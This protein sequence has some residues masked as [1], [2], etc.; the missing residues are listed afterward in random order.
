M[1][2][3]IIEWSYLN[4]IEVHCVSEKDAVCEQYEYRVHQPRNF[5]HC[6]NINF[7]TI[8]L[9]ASKLYEML[10]PIEAQQSFLFLFLF[11]VHKKFTIE[12][13]FRVTMVTFDHNYLG[14]QIETQNF[15]HVTT[16]RIIFLH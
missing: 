2:Q 11:C 16:C 5:E 9:F 3:E 13:F 14:S 1:F 7:E 12:Y 4:L 6:C 15:G 10:I 8:S